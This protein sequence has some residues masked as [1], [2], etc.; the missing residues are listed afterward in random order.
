MLKAERDDALSELARTLIEANERHF[1][2]EYT[3]EVKKGNIGAF[4][5]YR[6]A[7]TGLAV[8]M[9]TPA[10]ILG[11]AEIYKAETAKIEVLA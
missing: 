5:A 2:A 1:Y 10:G 9:S 11:L 7:M 4:K 6:Q 3:S 8:I